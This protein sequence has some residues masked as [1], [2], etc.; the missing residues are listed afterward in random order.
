M[1]DLFEQNSHSP[2]PKCGIDSS[3][4]RSPGPLTYVKGDR[5]TWRRVRSRMKR[6]DLDQFWNSRAIEFS[7]MNA[8]LR[9]LFALAAAL[10]S[11]G[12]IS[13]QPREQSVSDNEI[14]IGNLMPYTGA[15]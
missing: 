12:V 4:K 13:E 7:I 9:T 15:L 5:V 6:L 1:A 10:A 11:L 14:R 3:A 8:L 2:P